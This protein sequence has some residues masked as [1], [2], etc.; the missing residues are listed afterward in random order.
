MGQLALVITKR[1]KAI[2]FRE[3]KIIFYHDWGVHYMSILPIE[4]N[5]R[6]NDKYIFIHLYI[7]DFKGGSVLKNIPT[8]QEMQVQ[9][10]R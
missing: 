10:L 3:K 7:K 1:Q 6:G 5:V 8:N 2:L 9:S 4:G